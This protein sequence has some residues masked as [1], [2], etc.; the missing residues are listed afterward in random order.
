[1]GK[2]LGVL[3]ASSILDTLSNND[4]VNILNYTE[5]RSN[6]TIECFKDL[7]VQA[8]EENIKVFKDELQKLKPTNKTD[9][10]V[11][12]ETAFKLLAHVSLYLIQHVQKHELML[13][14][15]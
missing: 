15:S 13:S 12:L 1:M 9:I 8:T 5:G 6:Y 11:G 14:V 3:T 4:Y 10:T 7:L 2:H